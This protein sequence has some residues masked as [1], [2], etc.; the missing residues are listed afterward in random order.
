M[1]DPDYLSLHSSWYPHNKASP[2]LLHTRFSFSTYCSWIPFSCGS[3]G[4]LFRLSLM[5][6]S[7]SSLICL[8]ST[9]SSNL[10]RKTKPSGISSPF[11]RF[12]LRASTCYI[13][14]PMQFTT[15]K[16]N[17]CNCSHQ[18]QILGTRS[19]FT[20]AALTALQSVIAL[21]VIPKGRCE[22]A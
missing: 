2:T 11:T 17:S 1:I 19:F 15:V 13:L 16:L 20:D 18:R 14:A 5:T 6:R 9:Q 22:I 8:A 7:L 12:R 3:C 10:M 4:C 21:K